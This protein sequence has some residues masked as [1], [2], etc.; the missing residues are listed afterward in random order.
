MRR[1]GS[2]GRAMKSEENLSLHF[3]FPYGSL[4]MQAL[5]LL[6]HSSLRL[7]LLLHALLTISTITTTTVVVALQVTPPS[8]FP[9][10]TRQALIQKSQQ[11]VQTAGTYSTAGF[12]N[13]KGLVLTPIAIANDKH[14]NVYAADR[15]FLWNN[16][17]VMG[18]M[19]VVELPSS[20]NQDKPDLW[21]HSPVALDVPLQ[22]AIDSIGTVKHIVSP[23]YEH[24]K[25][26]SQW[27]Q[28]YPN[29]ELWGCPG[30]VERMPDL[31]WSG[32]IPNHYRP[33]GFQG[34]MAPS[35]ALPSNFWDSSLMETL[36][37]DMEINPFTGKP[38]F[39]ECIF[40]HKPTGSL[41]TTDF[42]WNYPASVIPNEQYGRNDVWEL[43]PTVN[44][45][46]FMSRLWKFGMDKVYL[47]FFE[48][49]MVQDKT[50]YRQLVK[51]VVDEWDCEIVVPA[52]GDVLRGKELVRRALGE[53]FGYP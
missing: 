50:A 53:F 1:S 49:L 9:V 31:D 51:H 28:A 23:N 20:N 37:V 45:V 41:I 27:K 21:I 14:C 44:E 30:F 36:H 43:A 35:H 48:N 22:K 17:D 2:A 25:Y 19:A 40:H 8:V 6:S 52:H 42:F 46:P 18:R 39:N 29:A 10:S 24:V 15:P 16:I 26:A 32:E 33:A 47:P 11:I 38:F 7:F 13:R 3:S 12:S 5:V 34:A 4:I